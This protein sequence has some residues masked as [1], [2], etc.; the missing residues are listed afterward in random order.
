MTRLMDLVSE[1]NN[2]KKEIN[3]EVAEPVQKLVNLVHEGKIESFTTRVGK[4][5]KLKEGGYMTISITVDDEMKSKLLIGGGGVNFEDC[6][7]ADAVK[8]TSPELKKEL[9][10]LNAHLTAINEHVGRGLNVP[11]SATYFFSKNRLNGEGGWTEEAM[12]DFEMLPSF[13]KD[14]VNLNGTNTVTNE[15]KKSKVI[16]P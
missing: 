2:L 4:E 8:N 3:K 9:M 14:V 5:S 1:L 16:R 6:A 13:L 11:M 7:N 10:A 15:E 12:K